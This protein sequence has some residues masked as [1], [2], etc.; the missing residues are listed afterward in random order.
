MARCHLLRSG[1][2][3]IDRIS[4]VLN[5][6]GSTVLRPYI[7]STVGVRKSGNDRSLLS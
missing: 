1:F 4:Y 5:D 3:I 6:R 7:K 2:K